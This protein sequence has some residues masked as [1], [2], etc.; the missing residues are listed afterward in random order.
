MFQVPHHYL[1]NSETEKSVL[2][3]VYRICGATSIILGVLFLTTAIGFAISLRWTGNNIVW[4][5]ALQSNWLIVIF[6]L[7]A[8]LINIQDNPLHGLHLLDIMI[9]ILFSLICFGLYTA[10]KKDSKIW[11]F[12]SFG[13]SLGTIILFV[14]TQIA[15]RST[16]MLSVII[17]SFIMRKGKIFN[18]VIIYSGIF[19]GVFLFVGDLSVGIQSIIITSLFGIGYVLIIAWFFMIGRKLFWLAPTK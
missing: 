15:G 17:F 18:N 12:I 9:L 6:K 11:S 13:L 4:F 19:A 14:A 5:S 8:G 7:H 16:V 1:N 3:N 10:L 2:I